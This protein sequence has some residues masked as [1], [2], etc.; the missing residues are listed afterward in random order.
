MKEIEFYAGE[1]IQNA[2]KTLLKESAEC[3]E[4]CFGTFNGQQLLSTDTLDEAYKKV[5]GL[6]K[7][8]F[9]EQNRKEYEEYKCREEEF[10]ASIPSKTEEYKKVARGVIIE[11]QYDYWDKIVSIRLRDLYH[12]ME[13]DATL[14]ICR[15]MRDESISLEKR[16][17]K[18]KEAFNNQGHSGMSAGLVL[19]MIKT[20]CPDGMVVYN[21]IEF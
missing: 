3:G 7:S 1:T 17:E 12:G 13:L 21:R 14:E 20:F 10:I 4:T 8:E 11:D 15:I 18:A 5:T 9:D 6:T 16:I 19:S 2:W